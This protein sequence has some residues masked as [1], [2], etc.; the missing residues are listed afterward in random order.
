MSSAIVALHCVAFPCP[1]E[2][3]QQSQVGCGDQVRPA[4]YQGLAEVGSVYQQQP[5]I[6]DL[7]VVMTGAIFKGQG[8]LPAYG[9]DFRVSKC[10]LPGA[11]NF[12][13]SASEVLSK[14]FLQ[15]ALMGLAE[16]Q[17]VG[18]QFH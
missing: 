11:V 10:L 13:G 6:M 3:Q 14:S 9:P 5:S 2:S 8:D 4:G 17:T 18:A 1:R 12:P 15:F 7:G 16:C